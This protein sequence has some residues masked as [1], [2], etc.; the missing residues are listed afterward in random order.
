VFAA[1]G[2]TDRV[3]Q[4]DTYGEITAD[5]LGRI[6]SSRLY[7]WFGERRLHPK[8]TLVTLKWE[9]ICD[10]FPS[11]IRDEIRGSYRTIAANCG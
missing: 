1:L 10:Q 2:G 9:A 4:A 11:L 3:P 7:E 5:H 8:E 6:Y